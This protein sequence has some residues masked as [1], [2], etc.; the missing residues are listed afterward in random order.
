MRHT[1][2]GLS[3]ALSLTACGPVAGPG[4]YKADFKSN[5]LFFTQMATPVD[6]SGMDAAKFVHKLQRTWFSS[7]V[8]GNF[9]SETPEGTVAIKE[10]L[11][12]NAMATN[13]FVMVKKSKDT[14]YYEV[15]KTDGT[16]NDMMPKGNNVEMCHGCHTAFKDTDYLGGTKLKN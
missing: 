16:L 5:A 6:N 10:T 8:Q 13:H 2:P 15:R 3:L 12:G 7:N 4:E 14:W 1:L 9:T 11:D